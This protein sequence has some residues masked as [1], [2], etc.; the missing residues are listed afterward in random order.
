MNLAKQDIDRF[1]S[2]VTIDQINKCWIWT[3]AKDRDGY[4]VFS[5]G[6]AHR[7]SAFLSGLNITNKL[8]CHTCDNPSCVNPS[9]LF[10]GTQKDN[11]QDALKKRR[12]YVG[13]KNGRS[14]LTE[15][16]VKEILASNL[17]GQQLADKFGV[18][19][20][21]INNVRRGASWQK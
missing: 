18:T 21:T 10:V 20:S 6:K 1:W 4:G 16:N 2:K 12:H 14:K 17:N 9:H 19:R 3:A 11:A 13:E 5:K 15:E 7:V 8:V